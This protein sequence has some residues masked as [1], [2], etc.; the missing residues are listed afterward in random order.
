[1]GRGAVRRAELAVGTRY[2]LLCHTSCTGHRFPEAQGVKTSCSYQLVSEEELVEKEQ[3]PEGTVPQLNSIKCFA[4]THRTSQRLRVEKSLVHHT[5]LKM[6]QYQGRQMNSG[7]PLPLLPLLI[8]KDAIL[9]Q[10]A[11]WI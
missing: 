4:T 10:E 6:F 3:I 2:Y 9:C 1:M 7:S 8:T 11:Q 5:G